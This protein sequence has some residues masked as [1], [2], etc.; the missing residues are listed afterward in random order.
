MTLAIFIQSL[1]SDPVFFVS[2]AVTVI[3]SITL[4]ELAH[5][6]AAIRLGDDTPLHQDRMTIN[7][8]VHM[9]PRSLIVLALFGIAWGRM[10]ISPGR[11]RGRHAE[12]LVAAAGPASNLVLGLLGLIA[13][14]LWLRFQ[15]PSPDDT[16]L[17]E[18]GRMFLYLFGSTNFLLCLFNLAP[19]P[20]LDGSHILANYHRGY[21]RW[22]SDASS[23]GVMIL[24][25]IAVFVFGFVL[26][27]AAYGVAARRCGLS[28][29]VSGAMSARKSGTRASISAPGASGAQ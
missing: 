12:A 14:G 8:L 23:Q 16:P 17:V 9:G 19:V 6:A 11:L 2:V 10:P 21:R 26:W 4:H 5:G 15:L 18:N 28:G 3:V 25:F 1:E 29:R 20:P 22:I 27:D 7:P 24:L 13:L